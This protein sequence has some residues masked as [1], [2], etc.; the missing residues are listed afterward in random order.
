MV[1]RTTLQH[2]PYVGPLPDRLSVSGGSANTTHT[3]QGSDADGFKG[4]YNSTGTGSS[5]GTQNIT[6]TG[7]APIS[8]GMGGTLTV[9]GTAAGEVFAITPGPNSG[10]LILTQSGAEPIT[11]TN[12]SAVVINANAGT[13]S[14]SLDVPTT[15]TGPLTQVSYNA[16][17]DGGTA[18]VL[19]TPTTL[20]TTITGG[21]GNDAV[22]ITGAAN[23][24]DSIQGNITVDAGASGYDTLS[25]NDTGNTTPTTYTVGTSTVSRSGAGTITYLPA[26]DSLS[27]AT[28]TA[29]DLVRVTASPTVA[30]NLNGGLPSNTPG[31]NLEYDAEN[32]T[33]S[34]DF[35]PPDG[36]IQSPGVQDVTYT[37]FETVQFVNV[38]PTVTVNDVSQNEGTSVGS[39]NFDFTVT[40]NVPATSPVTINYTVST[41]SGANPV[42]AADFPG[43]SFPSGLIVIPVGSK[44]G[45]ISI[46]VLA[47]SIFEAN[48]TFALTLTSSSASTTV[49]DADPDGVGT[50]LNDDAAPVVTI[51]DVTTAGESGSAVFTV[52]LSNQSEEDVTVSYSTADGTATGGGVDYTGGS[53]SVTISA[54]TTSNTISIPISSDNID[55]P[56]ETFFVN[57]TAASSPT[58]PVTIGDNQGQATITDD[59]NPPVITLSASSSSVSEGNSGTTSITYTV[60]LSNP[61]SQA[62]TVS[63]ATSD[64]TA[65]AGSDYQAASG[66]L[67]FLPGGPLSQT[68]TVLVNGDTTYEDNETFTVALTG[69]VNGTLGSPSASTATITN[70]DDQPSITIG[71]VT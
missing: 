23:K 64:G 30:L 15:Y 46:P 7:L 53:G 41:G 17:T 40:L 16:G 2:I 13:D 21:T 39:T 58:L 70:D 20:A 19:S 61:S 56:N 38:T 60:T 22:S 25:I 44:T 43:G 37:N 24:L 55:E 57:L 67:T 68:F 35:T 66:T 49:P 45:T 10:E 48:Q 14:F 27:L 4:T 28:G 47:D 71:T 69:S 8:D 18:T 33:V 9:T 26:L 42:T 6:Y 52:S 54:G 11:F 5:S 1:L 32:R 50:I 12:R 36:V 31:D 34:G 62:V 59:D 65:Q 63:Y 3:P 51:D 29:A